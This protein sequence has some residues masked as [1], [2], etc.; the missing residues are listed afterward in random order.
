MR[1]SDFLGFQS[2]LVF[3][4]FGLGAITKAPNQDQAYAAARAL[5]RA[6]TNYGFMMFRDQQASAIAAEQEFTPP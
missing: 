2:Q 4:T 1:A 5:N 6:R 3:P